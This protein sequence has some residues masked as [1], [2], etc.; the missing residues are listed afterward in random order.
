MNESTSTSS[1]L[2]LLDI[3][4]HFHMNES[5]QLYTLPLILQITRCFIRWFPT[6]NEHEPNEKKKFYWKM[7]H[8]FR[9]SSIVCSMHTD[10]KNSWE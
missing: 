5:F 10:E 2:C 3:F 8:Q 6:Q 1:I 9:N 7:L 4:A